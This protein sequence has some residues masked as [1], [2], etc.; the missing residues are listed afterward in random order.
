MNREVVVT[1]TL[2]RRGFLRAAALAGALP[3]LLSGRSAHSAG[4]ELVVANYG[5]DWNDRTVRFLE[6]PLVEKAGIKIL[7]E[8]GS[9]DERKMK[10]RAERQLPR[11]TIDIAHLS[12]AD[13]FELNQQALVEPLDQSRIPNYAHVHENLR[14]TYSV[15][16]LYSGLVVLY[17]PS[18]VKVPPTS[19]ADLWD[20]KYAGKVG[21]IDQSYFLYMQ[22]AALLNGGSLSNTEPGKEMLLQ[23]KKAVSPRIYPGQDQMAAGF[24]NEEIWIAP[25]FKARALQWE[26]DGIP[27]ATSYPKEGAL[28]I[29]FGAVMPKRA[30]H[31][32][33][34]YFYLNAMLDAE[35]M[36]GLAAASFYSPAVANAKLPGDVAKKIEFSTEE[37]AKLRFSDFGYMA[38]NSPNWLEWWNKSF[39]G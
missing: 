23:L 11:G 26:R 2:D 19:F 39:K 1:T 10:M 34:A 33:N 30:P 37:Q 24:K 32:E 8:F 3:S 28:A 22:V 31:K 38:A 27:V 36:G 6:A 13:A 16:W 17:N 15:P 25:N 20:P 35:A 21:L 9:A 4:G 12:D 18:K 7:H 14:T 5:G 29:T